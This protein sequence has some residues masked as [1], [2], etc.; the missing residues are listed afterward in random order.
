LK[1]CY[2][3][4][5]KII[6]ARKLAVDV[7]SQQLKL[8]QPMAAPDETSREKLTKIKGIGQVKLQVWQLF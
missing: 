5:Q 1:A 7:H 4:S 2:F 3:N 6:Y 8:E